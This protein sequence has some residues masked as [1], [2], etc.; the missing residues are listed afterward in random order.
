M[1]S[2]PDGELKWILNAQDH[3]TKFCHL[4]PLKAKTAK[5]VA[6]CLYEIFCRFGAPV[7]LYSDNGKEFRNE[8]ITSLQ[9]LWPDLQIVHGRAKR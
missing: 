7:V 4:R 5:E 1:Q 9:L 6:L 2:L 8:L 3:L